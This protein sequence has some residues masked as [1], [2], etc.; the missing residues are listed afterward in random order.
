MKSSENEQNEEI[1]WFPTPEKPV[2]EEEHTPIQQRI[3]MEIRELIEKKRIRP[4]QK[5]RFKEKVPRHVLMGSIPDSR[6]TL[7][8]TRTN[9]SRIQ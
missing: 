5:C 3:L 4:N 9:N 7:R 8:T 6:Q 2:N 1:F